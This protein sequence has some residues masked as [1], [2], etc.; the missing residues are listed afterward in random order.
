MGNISALYSSIRLGSTHSH[1]LRPLDHRERVGAQTLTGP[2]PLCPTTFRTPCIVS[3]PWLPATTS[4]FAPYVSD[5]NSSAAPSCRQ[6]LRIPTPS[7]AVMI[8][9]T[10]CLCRE[11]GS[12]PK[13]SSGR[14]LAELRDAPSGCRQY[15][16]RA[17]QMDRPLVSPSG[18]QGN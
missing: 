12:W 2:Q 11:L 5:R 8:C 14:F 3:T 7:G 6:A 16:P 9:A 17:G 10:F 15:N 4:S 1:A 13:I 18:L